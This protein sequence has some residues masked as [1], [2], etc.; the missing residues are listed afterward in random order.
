[1]SC[2]KGISHTEK[3]YIGGYFNGHIKSTLTSY[4]DVHGGFDFRDRKKG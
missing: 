2:W 4:N 3:F 1:M